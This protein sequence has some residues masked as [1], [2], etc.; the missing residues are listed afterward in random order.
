MKLQSPRRWDCL[1]CRREPCA[2]TSESLPR[3]LRFYRPPES[4]WLVRPRLKSAGPIWPPPDVPAGDRLTF[5]GTCAGSV[6]AGS[7]PLKPSFRKLAG[8]YRRTGSKSVDARCEETAFCPARNGSLLQVAKVRR[9]P[10]NPMLQVA[11]L[12]GR[13]NGISDHGAS[14]TG[15]QSGCAASAS[16]GPSPAT[17]FSAARRSP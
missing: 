10:V 3:V 8:W 5:T 17:V 2:Q 11:H 13:C 9:Q 1:Q 16:G 7:R 12:S 14:G 6:C 15:R 4:T